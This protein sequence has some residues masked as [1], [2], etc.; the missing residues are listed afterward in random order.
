MSRWKSWWECT[1]VV[2]RQ[3]SGTRCWLAAQPAPS[4]APPLLLQALTRQ[5]PQQLSRNRWIERGTGNEQKKA[6]RF[7]ITRL[8]GSSSNSSRSFSIPIFLFLLSL[9]LLPSP[10]KGRKT[11]PESAHTAEQSPRKTVT[12]TAAANP[13]G[14]LKSSFYMG[15]SF[16][17]PRP[18][19]PLFPV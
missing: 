17:P 11:S 9:L 12:A 6:A 7:P 13:L 15:I 8:S 5:Q 19:T 3:R 16:P 18:T 14:S 1:T 4:A 10:A 2:A